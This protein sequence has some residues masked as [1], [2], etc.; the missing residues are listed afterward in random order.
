[1]SSIVVLEWI[2][3][4]SDYF[5]PRNEIQQNGHTILIAN[6]KAKVSID[7][8]VYDANPSIRD[9]LHKALD[10]QFKGILLFSHEPYELSQR[11]SKTTLHDD[12][13]R[14]IELGPVSI[15]TVSKVSAHL[16]ITNNG[17]VVADTRRDMIE[18]EES[19]ANLYNK[20]QTDEIFMP[21][22]RSYEASVRDQKD[23]FVHLYEIRDAL[24][25]K[26]GRKLEA[27]L[28]ISHD[29]WSLFGR[30]CDEE[31]L[32]PSRHRGKKYGK[33]RDATDAELSEAR[34]IALAMI[35]AHDSYLDR[36]SDP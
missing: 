7:S 29:D 36:S 30:L 27:T 10:T 22:L 23:E 13:N 16:T 17:I 31:P 28:N 5:E 12:G 2:F 34:R 19:L 33:L 8:T 26:F 4:P 35:E 14:D 25:R 21:L 24:Y 20:H 32:Q 9:V 11:P 3:S 1:M 6:G 18:K 15:Q